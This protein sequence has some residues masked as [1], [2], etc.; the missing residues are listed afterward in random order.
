[1][2]ICSVLC[3][4]SRHSQ[5][6]VLE[7]QQLSHTGKSNVPTVPAKYKLNEFLNSP[8]MF[9]YNKFC[10]TLQSHLMYVVQLPFSPVSQVIFYHKNG[11]FNTRYM[12]LVVL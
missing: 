8:Y 10:V 11:Y 12:A 3:I 4:W 9:V 7:H 5:H 2:Y 6:F 1:M